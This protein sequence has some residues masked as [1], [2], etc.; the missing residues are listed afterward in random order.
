MS[1]RND[2]NV[3][4]VAICAADNTRRKV[5]NIN[6]PM[7]LAIV[8]GNGHSGASAQSGGGWEMAAAT[9]DRGFSRAAR[10]GPG[11]PERALRRRFHVPSS[12]TVVETP[13]PLTGTISGVS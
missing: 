4:W 1:C 10:A 9:P 5:D 3:V 11:A 8:R 7:P 13:R 6:V 2:I 12:R